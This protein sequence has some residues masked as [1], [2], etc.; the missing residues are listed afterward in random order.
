MQQT[1]A[2]K[3]EPEE[4][5]D[6]EELHMLRK[7]KGHKN[8]YKEKFNL[9]KNAKAEYNDAQME[10]DMM[11]ERLVSSFENWYIAEFDV[12]VQGGGLMIEDEANLSSQEW[13]GGTEANVDAEQDTFMR[14]KKKVEILNRARKMDKRR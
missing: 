10:G 1:D 5:I 11:K 13:L 14:A 3:D 6:E 7:M 9:L 8:D 2:F 4:I 12:P